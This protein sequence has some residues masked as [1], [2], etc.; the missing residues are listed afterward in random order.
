MKHVGMNVASDALMTMAYLG[1]NGGM[2]IINADD[3]SLFSSQN[4]QD[5][6]YF[7]R[8]SG[9]PMLEP[10]NAQEMK[11]MTIS[12]FDLSENSSCPLF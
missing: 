3:P 11:D 10:I 8:L 4:E 2:V 1:V 5:N 6:R 7:S 12:A 9:L